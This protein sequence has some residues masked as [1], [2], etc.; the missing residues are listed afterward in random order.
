MTSERWRQLEELYDAMKDLS[1]AARD[2]RL[3]DTDPELRSAM[4]AILAQDRSAH[5][6]SALEHPAWES[7][8]SLLQTGTMLKAGMQLGPYKIDAK[9][10]REGWEK[11]TLPPILVWPEKSQ[12]KL[13]VRNLASDFKEKLARSRA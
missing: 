9:S 12:S 5:E 2:V 13:A 11:S 3:K 10:A 1:P 8:A 6:R 4:E 7:H